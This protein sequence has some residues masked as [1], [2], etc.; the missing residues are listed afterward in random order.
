[1][2][3]F[4]SITLRSPLTRLVRVPLHKSHARLD[5]LLHPLPPLLLLGQHW[6][7]CEAGPQFQICSLLTRGQPSLFDNGN[8]RV[9]IVRF[10]GLKKTASLQSRLGLPLQDLLLFGNCLQ[11]YSLPS[12]SRKAGRPRSFWRSRHELVE[13]DVLLWFVSGFWGDGRGW[14]G[15]GFGIEHGILA[16]LSS[17]LNPSNPLLPDGANA[18]VFRRRCKI[19]PN[20]LT[21][22]GMHPLPL[23]WNP[24]SSAL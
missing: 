23:V 16:L 18:Q 1:M 12:E 21:W 6:D 10:F 19:G 22:T 5:D 24:L 3:R 17:Q 9:R 11:I 14:R 7:S 2:R 13:L 8:H 15:S 4:L 20:S